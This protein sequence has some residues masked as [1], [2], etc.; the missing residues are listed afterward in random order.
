MNLAQTIAIIVIAWL[1]CS[2]DTQHASSEQAGNAI[3]DNIYQDQ[4]DAIEKAQQVEQ[5]LLDAAQSQRERIDA[6]TN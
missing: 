6:Q 4:F 1:A 5:V 3:Q 2:C